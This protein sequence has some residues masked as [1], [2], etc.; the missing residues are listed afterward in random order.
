MDTST[1]VVGVE[2]AGRRKA[3]R[4]AYTLE[5]KRRI[6]GEASARG[7]SVAEVARVHGLN[8]NLVF[9]WRRQHQQGVLEE[10]TRQAKLLPVEVRKPAPA[11]VQA[12]ELGKV[13]DEGRIEIVL[14]EDIRVSII[15]SVAA[16]RLEDL[17]RSR[18]DRSAPRL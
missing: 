14:G 17:D 12:Q 9:T 1:V 18:Y 15:G 11:G 3:Q 7:A 2:K 6:V 16:E 5:E 8:A 4:R 10:H 13:R